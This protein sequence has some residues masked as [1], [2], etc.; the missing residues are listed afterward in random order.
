VQAGTRPARE[1]GKRNALRAFLKRGGIIAYPT[2]SCFGLGCDPMNHKAVEKILKLKGRGAAKGLILIAASRHQ[3]RPYA[4]RTSIE[5]AWQ[6]GRWP[7]PVTWVLP[8][9]QTCPEWLTG[10]RGTVAVRIT[11]HPGAAALCREAGMA[12][13]STSANKSGGK[14]AKTWQQCLRLFGKR[15][16]VLKGRIGARKRPSTLIDLASGK[17]L[18]K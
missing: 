9:A 15:V 13:V 2:E 4:T 17:L 1:G 6:K 7:G 10:G 3:L 12:L 16:R 18:R 5:A 14:P 11:A 8:A